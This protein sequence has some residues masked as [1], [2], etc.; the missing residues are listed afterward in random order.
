MSNKFKQE[1]TATTINGSTVL[2]HNIEESK[3]A[4]Q[5]LNIIYALDI[6]EVSCEL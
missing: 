5:I 6:V 4:L 1:K 2:N 3:M